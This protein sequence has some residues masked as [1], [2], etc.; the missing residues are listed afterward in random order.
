M[1]EVEA[2]LARGGAGSLLFVTDPATVVSLQRLAVEGHR[3]GIPAPFG[4]DVLSGLRTI[5]PVPI[6]LAASPHEE[7]IEQS[8]AVAGGRCAGGAPWESTG[9]SPRTSGRQCLAG[10]APQGGTRFFADP[11][12]DEETAR[13]VLVTP[14]NRDAAQQAAEASAVLLRNEGGP[15]ALSAEQLGT[16]AAFGPHRWRTRAATSSSSHA[17]L[18]LRAR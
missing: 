3:L 7:M 6:A 8:Q 2:A 13:E 9:T 1:R 18:R 16:V 4:F 17:R 10:A 12:G 14:A 15:P 5:F 11:Y